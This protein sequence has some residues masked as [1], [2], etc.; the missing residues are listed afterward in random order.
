[1][2]ASK[3]RAISAYKP[4]SYVSALNACASDAAAYVY[5]NSYYWWWY[6]TPTSRCHAPERA[7]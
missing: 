6:S 5:G 2:Q 4:D 1:M 7:A 3:H